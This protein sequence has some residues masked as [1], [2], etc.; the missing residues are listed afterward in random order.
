MSIAEPDAVMEE[1]DVARSDA[2]LVGRFVATKEEAA[3]AELVRRHSGL[4]MSV[5]RRVLRDG[6]DIDDV[7]QATFLV[8]VRDAVR[9]K[10]QASLASWLYGVAYRLAVRVAQQ[11]QQRRETGLVDDTAVGD[12]VLTDLADRYDQ[13][14]VD[15]ELNALPERYRQPLVLKYLAGKTPLEVASELKLTVGAVEGLLKRG[16]Q[17]LRARL[18]KRGVKLGAAVIAVQMTRQAVQAACP[19]QLLEE[20]IRTGLAWNSPNPPP[21]DLISDRVLELTLKE[22][23]TMTTLTKTGLTIGLTTGALALGLGGAGFLV[24]QFQDRASAG[25][26]ATV[27][28]ASSASNDLITTALAAEPT[29]TETLFDTEIAITPPAEANP[30]AAPPQP[31]ALPDVGAAGRP[32]NSGN[33]ASR[34]PNNTIPWDFKPRSVLV[35]RIEQSLLQ[36]TEVAFTDT[37]LEEAIKLLEDL[38]SIRIWLDKETLTADGINTDSPINLQ[39][40]GISLN[41]ALNLMLEPL[42][43]DYVIKNEVMVITTKVRS[44]E[45]IETRVYNVARIPQLT[46]QELIEIIVGSSRFGGEHGGSGLGKDGGAPGGKAGS[47]AAP[48]S[49][50]ESAGRAGVASATPTELSNPGLLNA[51]WAK[52]DGEGGAAW[53]GKSILIVQHTQRVHRQIV[54]LLDQLAQTETAPAKTPANASGQPTGVKPALPAATPVGSSGNPYGNAG[55]PTVPTPRPATVPARP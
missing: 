37:P 29:A 10:K 34:M 49:G 28:V 43:L 9:V 45:M 18:M 51:K 47:A 25:I 5:C 38:H 40:S 3:F 2:E 21:L 27:P 48:M 42:Q 53:A 22:L 36:D 1:V 50:V 20:T 32:A 52:I 46:P 13:Q 19:K 41:S 4:V 35:K 15:A 24:S 14:L 11:R 12:D 54:E 39:M 23:A 30:V 33:A 26:V 16:K 7:F 17:E 6:H 8:F 44:E 31:P 55:T